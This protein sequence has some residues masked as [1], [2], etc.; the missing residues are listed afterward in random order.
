[1]LYPKR[2]LPS[3]SSSSL[4]QHGKI[5]SCGSSWSFAHIPRH[6]NSEDFRIPRSLEC[7][8]GYFFFFFFAHLIVWISLFLVSPWVN[9]NHAFFLTIPRL[10]YLL[11]L[12]YA[13]KLGRLV[14]RI[15]IESLGLRRFNFL[16]LEI[17]WH[18]H[19]FVTNTN[20]DI[21]QYCS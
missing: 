18:W 11:L 14:A 8:T 21:L 2:L 1:M 9:M 7:R 20:A 13:N 19:A 4:A 5:S 17:I 6:G 3:W 10:G 15:A 16:F 12:H